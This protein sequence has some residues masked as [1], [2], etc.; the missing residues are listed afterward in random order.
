MCVNLLHSNSKLIEVGE[1]WLGSY[2]VLMSPLF[3][4]YEIFGVSLSY[5]CKD[6]DSKE[7]GVSEW[8]GE[9]TLE[10]SCKV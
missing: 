6:P 4:V 9:W 2:I 3:H 8:L 10:S 1:E 5:L 7:E